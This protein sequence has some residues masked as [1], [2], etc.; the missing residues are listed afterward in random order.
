M[1]GKL[2]REKKAMIIQ[3]IARTDANMAG[4]VHGGSIRKL[5]GSTVGRATN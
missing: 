5:V 2:A 1:E 3:Q 4:S